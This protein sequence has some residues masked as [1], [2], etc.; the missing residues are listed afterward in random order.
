M[1]KYWIVIVS[2]ITIVCI[3][4]PIGLILTQN[5]TPTETANLP[6][7]PDN[8]TNNESET[9]SEPEPTEEPVNQSIPENQDTDNDGIPDVK[10]IELHKTDPFNEDSD[11]DLINDYDEIY[12]YRNAY[13]NPLKKNPTFKA[14]FIDRNLPFGILDIILIFDDDELMEEDERVLIYILDEN[15]DNE[16]FCELTLPIIEQE[17]VKDGLDP[18]EAT[19]VQ[20]IFH[21]FTDDNIETW[22]YIVNCSWFSSFEEDKSVRLTNIL[23]SLEYIISS[24]LEIVENTLPDNPHLTSELNEKIDLLKNPDLI[25]TI[26]EEELYYIDFYLSNDGRAI[27]ITIVFPELEMKKDAINMV[28]K[29]K[30]ALF[31]FENFLFSY[32]HDGLGIKYGFRIGACGGGGGIKIEDR[33]TYDSRFEEGMVPYDAIIYHEIGHSYVGNEQINQFLEI[34]VYNLIN[35]GS[36]KFGDWIYV[37]SYYT[38]EFDRNGYIAL[39][40]IYQLIG[41]DKM[42][43]AY[44]IVCEINPAYG[45]PL[46]QECIQAFIDQAPEHLRL[47]VTEHAYN[48]D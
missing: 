47:Q 34:Y 27:P 15:Q 45:E 10:E 19:Y 6:S 5:T 3:S 30:I 29:S 11:G 41:E 25:N 35:T 26:L 46:P 39:L 8:S 16:N 22:N 9:P 40:E 18:Q 32:P 7:G 1:K 21:R 48:I 37:R 14:A 33:K 2:I 20:S 28:E 44:R 13:L 4:V 12:G 38:W 31:H 43:N 24:E 23:S 17:W 42:A 36:S